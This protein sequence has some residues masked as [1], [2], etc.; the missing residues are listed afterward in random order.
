M[1]RKPKDINITMIAKEAGLSVSTVSR[2]MNHRANVSESARRKID[3]LMRKYN[4]T[5]TPASPHE[6]KIALLAGGNQFN[7]YV[8]EVFNG[9][10]KYTEANALETTLIFR[11]NR[12]SRNLLEQI[13]DQQCSGVV[14]I[15]PAEFSDSLDL[16]AECELPVVL[17]DEAVY[18]DG[19][20]FIDHDSCS[21]SRDALKYLLELG[22]RN[23]GYIEACTPTLNHIQRYKAYENTMNEAG[24]DL[25]PDWRIKVDPSRHIFAGGQ[26]AMQELLTRAPELSA[27]MTTNDM[28]AI[29]AMHGAIEMGRRIPED[30]SI[31]G[32]DNYKHTE[33]LNPSLTTVNHP[34]E[35]AGFLAA[36]S[37]DECLKNP[38]TAKQQLPHEILPTRLI[39]RQST[40]PFT[41]GN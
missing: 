29:G 14:V 40:A 2:A 31:I 5:P 11:K 17:I 9:I 28:I 38:R 21:G 37:I 23:I 10:Y 39:I 19:I 20:G 4:F 36:K 6:K 12:S 7:D 8:A 22:H 35:E 3:A 18:R 27:V 41:P 24:L 15:L 32:F 13:R 16:L 1:G 34:I 33:F 30:I 25:R 26:A